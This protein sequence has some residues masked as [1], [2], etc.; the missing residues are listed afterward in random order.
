MP[1]SVGPETAQGN[2]LRGRPFLL[3]CAVSCGGFA[4]YSLLLS[5]VPL[6]A[7]A[8]GAG[9]AGAGAT[10]GVLMLT[11][12]LTQLAVPWLLRRT[13][14]RA[15]LAAGALLLGVPALA[16][17]ASSYLPAVL[18]VSALRGVGFG[19][20]TVAGA[21]LLARLVPPERHGR[22]IGVY[23]LA[24]GAPNLAFL[25]GGVWLA[26]QVGFAS[27]FVLAGILPLVA[28]ATVL[29][30][31]AGPAAVPRVRT[32]PAVV[33]PR[34][35]P[36]P[37]PEPEREK[38]TR[39]G[40]AA[41]AGPW[42]VMTGAALAT[43][44]LYTF[45]PLA[46]AHAGSWA[47]PAALLAFGAASLAGRWITGLVGDRV[48]R[49]RLLVPGVLI[50]GVGLLGPA[51]AAALEATGPAGTAGPAGIAGAAAVAGALLYGLGF[52]AV[53]NETLV[54]MFGRAG[55]GGYGLASAAWN[56]AFDAGTGL[57]AV[58]L[59]FVV[60]GMDYSAAFVAAAALVLA[61]LPV[62]LTVAR[63]SSSRPRRP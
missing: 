6:W 28:V 8:G 44:G 27:A 33:E 46:V 5:V 56:I 61:C 62:A 51:A 17:T 52:G 11:T 58:A 63:R 41:L 3:L 14:H 13:S 53:Q 19:M 20:L 29:A 38:A 42:T 54:A 31:D 60:E 7:V 24:V 39:A 25:P 40:T 50:A 37:A 1:G 23:G 47:A 10:T 49:G 18:A 32:R 21:A 36:E 48:G 35:E 26:Q 59:G 2:A 16:Y 55:P 9:D 43:G 4:N 30:M 45:L 12:V 57:G 22:A 15:V 34:P